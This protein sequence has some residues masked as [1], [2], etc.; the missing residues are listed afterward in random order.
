MAIFDFLKKHRK[1]TIGGAGCAILVVMLF[2]CGGGTIIAAL[3]GGY[4]T[5]SSDLEELEVPPP[6]SEVLTTEVAKDTAQDAAEDVSDLPMVPV[7]PR[8]ISVKQAQAANERIIAEAGLDPYFAAGELFSTI[9]TSTWPA[10]PVT[11]PVGYNLVLVDVNQDGELIEQPAVVELYVGNWSDVYAAWLIE[12]KPNPAPAQMGLL[13]AYSGLPVIMVE[14]MSDPTVVG[15][16]TLALCSAEPDLLL[17][18]GLK[19]CTD[20]VFVR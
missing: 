15:S 8:E 3:I 13:P 6:E 17:R 14:A 20:G 19:D 1:A 11:D 10:L 9:D 2:C 7:D 16:L 4:F 5:L 12:G 18:L